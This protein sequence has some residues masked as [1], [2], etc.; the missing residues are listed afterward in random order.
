MAKTDEFSALLDELN[1]V[2]ADTTDLSKSMDGAAKIA[3]AAEDGEDQG[4]AGDKKRGEPDGDKDGAGEGDN[5]GDEMFGKALQVQMADGTVAEAYDGTAMMK[6]MATRLVATEGQ[7]ATLAKALSAATGI[8]KQQGE[9][10]KALNDRVARLA[11]TG[12]GR[13]AMVSVND[14]APAPAAG[15]AAAAPAPQE[16]LTKALAMSGRGELTSIQVARIESSVRSGAPLPADLA[17]ALS[18]AA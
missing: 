12:T 10:M 8:I 11:N 9:M 6:A 14:K 2:Q 13:R 18:S 1:A 15:Q 5:D 17:A 7:S 16:L 4:E 3:A